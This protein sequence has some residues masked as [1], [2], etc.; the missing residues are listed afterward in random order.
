MQVKCL[1]VGAGEVGVG[2]AW[3]AE[4]A[5][6]GPGVDWRVL[7]GGG[8]GAKEEGQYWVVEPLKRKVGPRASNKHT[9][10][11]TTRQVPYCT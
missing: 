6:C 4:R 9:Y 10:T 5:G 3:V 2:V 1:R 8:G 11:Y 7:R